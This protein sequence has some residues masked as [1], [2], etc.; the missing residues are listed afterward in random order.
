VIVIVSHSLLLLLLLLS[1]LLLI[2]QIFKKSGVPSIRLGDKILEYSDSFRFYLTTNLS[3]P[4]YLPEV[5]IKV[6]LTNFMITPNGLSDQLL[7]IVVARERPELE[8][9]RNALI[10]ESAENTRQLK[11][12]EDRILFVMS[13]SQG[14]ILDDATA[15]E[16]LDDSKRL[17]NT[18]AI[19]VAE[20]KVTEVRIEEARKVY[21]PV[22]ERSTG[23]IWREPVQ[24]PQL[25]H[26][27]LLFHYSFTILYI[28]IICS[29]TTIVF[30]INIFFFDTFLCIMI[31]SFLYR[32]ALFYNT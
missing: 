26:K 21:V 10:V 29:L 23:K 7:G 9:A 8:T 17:S 31:P 1:T 24:K 11:E 16:T 25:K 2:T 4:H 13:S 27:S 22:A 14:N 28:Y 6:T 15:I 5:S 30:S 12:I 32:S 3:N 18:I 20:G 19:K